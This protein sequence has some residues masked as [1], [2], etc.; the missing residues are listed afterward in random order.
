MTGNQM[1]AGALPECYNVYG[2]E[3]KGTTKINPAT[4][5]TR[6]RRRLGF[7]DLMGT[8]GYAA[9][10]RTDKSEHLGNFR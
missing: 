3:P 6:L 2:R 4:S 5:R 7:V 10:A 8:E 9:S 1:E